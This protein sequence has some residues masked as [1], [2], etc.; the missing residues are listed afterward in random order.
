VITPVRDPQVVNRT[1]DDAT[2]PEAATAKV[3]M[4]MGRLKAGAAFSDLAMD[5]SEDPESTPRGGDMGL[6]PASQLRQVPAT[7]RDAVLKAEPGTVNV[8]SSSG[9]H[10]IVLVLSHERAGQ[11]DL[12]MPEVRTNIT[13]ALRARKEQ[14]LRTA[15]LALVRNEAAVE[16]HLARLLVENRGAVP[17]LLPAPP[18]R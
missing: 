12:S 7:L 13:N 16:N 15:Y 6:V 17:S 5:Y 9:G 2:T 8:V 14:L 10:I 1:G 11:R 3:E 18:G 4:L